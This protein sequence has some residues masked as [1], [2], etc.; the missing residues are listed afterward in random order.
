MR[1]KKEQHINS[2]L[3]DSK[4]LVSAAV[5]AVTEALRMHLNKHQIIC[6][7]DGNYNSDSNGISNDSIAVPLELRS[8]YSHKEN[9]RG[10]ITIVSDT[11]HTLYDRIREWLVEKTIA[12]AI[13][14]EQDRKRN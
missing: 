1:T 7:N 11:A 10:D 5:L 4:I 13:Q 9:E 2:F 14:M 12:S 6:Y 3:T 8:T